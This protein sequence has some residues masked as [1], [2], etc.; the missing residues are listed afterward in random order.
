VAAVAVTTGLVACGPPPPHPPAV[1]VVELTGLGGAV[2]VP[3]DINEVGV[4]AGNAD[5]GT[6]GLHAV[7]WSAGGELT[8]L[9]PDLPAAPGVA[10]ARALNDAGRVAGFVLAVA[11]AP[12]PHVDAATWFDGVTT[13]LSE[14][15]PPQ[16][17]EVA[18][19]VNE[20][21]DVLVYRN[22]L[23]QGPSRFSVWRDG[24]F[25]DDLVAGSGDELQPAAVGDSGV[26][27]GTR[28]RLVIPTQP[29]MQRVFTWRPGEEPIDVAMPAPAVNAS[30]VGV[31]ASDQVVGQWTD[32]GGIWRTFVAPADGSGGAV[33][34]GTLGGPQTIVAGA[35][36][37]RSEALNDRGDV[38][39][40]STTSS[41]A[42]HAFLWRDGA[43]VDLGTLGG[44]SSEAI[45]VNERRQVVGTSET[46]DGE[47][48]AFVWQAGRMTDLGAL[49]PAD[50]TSSRAVDINDCGQVVGAATAGTGEERAYR[51]TVPV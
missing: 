42:E 51:W 27:V 41:G 21:G 2:T 46:P 8:D 50:V 44:A 30:A 16:S 1:T 32:V 38:V 34:V 31:N 39:G 6:G 19:D 43:M 9:T 47:R 24:A 36:G 5:P 28:Q 40:T 12:G 15:G 37:W 35:N 26:V 17:F 14:G 20:P 23:S 10:E 7:T 22:L 29:L 33:D 45:A 11:P 13:N 48:H 4:V 49:L 18:M 25:V 3:H